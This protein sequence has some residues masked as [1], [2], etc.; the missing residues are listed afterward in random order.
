M[1]QTTSTES[2]CIVLLIDVTVKENSNEWDDTIQLL[3]SMVKYG[4]PDN[5]MF[6]IV[7]VGGNGSGHQR[8]GDLTGKESVIDY[9]E[10]SL[11]ALPGNNACNF[12]GTLDPQKKL[13]KYCLRKNWTNN[14]IE[15]KPEIL[16]RLSTEQRS[17]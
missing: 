12:W 7:L 14:Y 8:F 5:S 9:L 4:T 1:I 11:P 13:V 10:K 16:Q 6:A 15:M 3:T 17:Y 2:P